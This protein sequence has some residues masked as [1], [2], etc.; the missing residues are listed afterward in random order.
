MAGI[1]V[2][3]AFPLRSLLVTAE[4]TTAQPMHD[5]EELSWSAGT[6]ARYQYSPR[7][8]L[9]AGIGKRLSGPDGSWFVTVGSAY[10]FGLPWRR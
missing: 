9:D 1:A 3:R 2:D 5:G 8:A 7:W 10:A 4:L 6:G